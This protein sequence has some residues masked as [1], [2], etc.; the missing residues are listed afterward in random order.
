MLTRLK[1]RGLHICLW[2][3]PYIAERSGL[4][5]AFSR[6]HAATAALRLNF[7]RRWEPRC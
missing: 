5:E 7:E 1:A 3:N 4:F 6:L 2:I